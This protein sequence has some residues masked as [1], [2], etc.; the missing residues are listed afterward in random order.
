MQSLATAV[1]LW[2]RV[3]QSSP[4]S[5]ALVDLDGRMLLASPSLCALFGR[6]A[7][8]LASHGF[9]EITH[10]DD[11]EADLDLMRQAFAG[12]SD[13]YRLRK[14][15][16]HKQGYVG[17]ID[18]TVSLVRNDRGEPLHFL[19]QMEDAT[20]QMEYEQHLQAA[21]AEVEYER[22]TLEAIF[23]TVHVGLLLIGPDGNYQRMNRHHQENLREAFPEGH[24][25]QAGQLGSVYR[26]DGKRLMDKK[27]MPSYRAAQ[28]EEFDD[29][30]FWVGTDPKHRVAMSVSARQVRDPDGNRI[31]AALAYQDVTDL[32]RAMQVKDDFVSSVSHEL[33]TP[34]TTVLGHIEMLCEKDGLPPDVTVQ[35][36][37]VQR[38]ASRLQA[39]VED[40]LQVARANDGSIGIEPVITDLTTV[41]R[42]SIEAAL[43][44]AESQRV[45]LGVDVPV[46]LVAMVDPHR[47]RQVIDN[48][49][50]NAVKY[51]DPQ[52]AVTIALHDGSDAVEL[53]VS[54]TGI[55][56]PPDEV[57]SVFTRFFRGGGAL[58]K[59][60]PGTGLG[61]HIV[62]GIVVAHGGTVTLESEVGRGSTF[63]VTL[64]HATS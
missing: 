20:E 11:L 29:S 62:S 26:A 1:E 25:G 41:V 9:Q 31:G 46:R 52:G 24:A 3:M 35:L 53:E 4:I 39:L 18:L 6:D 38:N 14:R 10:P 19:C 36:K 59:H 61:L 54:D 58:A 51:T 33:R 21:H 15:F 47:I 17:W 28:G 45:T 43:P 22:Q 8:W 13:S 16:L 44:L 42:E 63:R 30:T 7:E 57:D 37:A 56:I 60:T 49:L 55:G 64:P 23:D 5:M 12:D 34:L 27:E 32:M 40:L 48:L 50:A 2:R